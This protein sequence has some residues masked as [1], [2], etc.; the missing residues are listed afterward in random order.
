[1]YG[2]PSYYKEKAK[3]PIDRRNRYLL[4][5]PLADLPVQIKDPGV[6]ELDDPLATV[7]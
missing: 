7:Q 2:P 5:D 6:S 4:T 3:L 1:M